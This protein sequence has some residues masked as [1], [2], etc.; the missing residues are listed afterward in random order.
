VDSWQATKKNNGI[1]AMQ[2]IVLDNMDYDNFSRQVAKIKNLPLP[3]VSSHYK[4]APEIRIEELKAGFKTRKEPKK[5]G[6]MALFYPDDDYITHLLLIQRKIYP[7]IHSGQ[8]GFPGGRMEKPD[9][10]I[11]ETALRE[12]SEEVGVLP[13]KIEVIRSLTKI[14]IPPSN[15]EVQPF[16]GLYKRE[17][18]FVSQEA[19]VEALV[20]VPLTDFMD[21]RNLITQNLSTSYARNIDVPAFRLNGHIV[22]GA[23]AMMLSEI[24]EIFNEAF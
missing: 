24:K 4:M 11:R 15:F 6:V 3:G 18:P 21:D 16:I 19:E 20:E 12:T 7:G 14:F 2:V 1:I 23:T 5:A 17:H 10:D 9:K 13:E 8:I 22:W